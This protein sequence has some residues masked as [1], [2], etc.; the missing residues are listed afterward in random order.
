VKQLEPQKPATMMS[1][2][3]KKIGKHSLVYGAGTMIG[4]LIGFLMVPFYTHFLAPADYGVLELLD[5]TS[6]FLSTVVGLG[7]SSA[8]VRF[9]YDYQDDRQR[10]EVVSSAM[11][12][13]IV[14]LGG[15]YVVL[16][17]LCPMFS[18]SLFSTRAYGS[19][20]HIIVAALCFD[21]LAELGISY[22]R[23]KQQS[24]T[25][26]A[27]TL[28]RLFMSL[29]LNIY[30]IVALRLG[31]LGILYSSLVSSGTM[32]V[33]L[34]ASTLREVGW[35]FSRAKLSAMVRYSLPLIPVSLGMFVLNFSDRFFLQHYASLSEV[36]I[37]S[38]GYKFGMASGVLITSPFLLFWGAYA[39]EVVERPDGRQLVARL[40]VYFTTVLL[41][42]T[43]AI[44][45]FAQ[46]L[47]RFMSPPDY[48]RAAHVIPIV[49]LAYVLVGMSYFFRVGLQYTKQTKYLSY[50]VGVSAL[51]NVPFN[52]ILIPRYHAM[53]AAWA[54]LLSFAVLSL[55]TCGVAQR[56][57]AIP[58]EYARL[59]KLLAAGVIIFAVSRLFP[60]AS[61]VPSLL[62]C[63][64][65]LMMLPLLLHVLRFFEVH[66][67]DRARAL[68]VVLARRVRPLREVP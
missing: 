14:V 26:T 13:G 9:F 68:T 58:F 59:A 37:Y 32:A 48:W 39:Y 66:E 43:L 47:V 52:F 65:C 18:E 22:I 3:L 33:V 31:V 51:L 17:P 45:M 15:V 50:A 16:Q 11:L 54:T 63:S 53:G 55:V 4:R 49:G 29:A 61:L 25:A 30:F 2:V 67:L 57:Y 36:G 28:G 38:L 46:P 40:Q 44:S 62:F 24:V 42:S 10:N 27:F 1:E 8:I 23:A 5:L 6:F 21:T 12:F 41:A 56:N 20:F 7:L 34:T 19:F 60:A 35:G 64:V